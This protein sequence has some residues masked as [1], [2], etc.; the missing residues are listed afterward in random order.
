[1]VIGVP[2]SNSDESW[3]LGSNNPNT[4]PDPT[5]IRCSRF[6]MLRY[7]STRTPFCVRLRYVLCFLRTPHFPVTFSRDF[8]DICFM[9]YLFTIPYVSPARTMFHYFTFSDSAVSPQPYLIVL[10][11]LYSELVLVSRSGASAP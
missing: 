10:R 5:R 11:L 9:L 4:I 7:V 3:V 6:C 8:V 2:S 1:M